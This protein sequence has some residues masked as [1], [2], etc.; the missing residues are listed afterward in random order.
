MAGFSVTVVDETGSF[1][2]YA[3]SIASNTLA[4][5]N[6]WQARLQRQADIEISVVIRPLV[7]GFLAQA[8]SLER[9]WLKLT[10]L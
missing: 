6:L 5:A 9:D 7:S 10:H 8:G 4:A 1:G 3:A 2:S